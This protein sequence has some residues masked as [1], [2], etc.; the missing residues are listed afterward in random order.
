M[1]IP[2]T[3][4]AFALTSILNA[5]GMKPLPATIDMMDHSTAISILETI[6][7]EETR[8]ELVQLATQGSVK[9]L[10]DEEMERLRSL[11]DDSTNRILDDRQQS[12]P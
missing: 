9:T 8:V 1:T 5:S 10:D 2:G 11:I 6:T 4:L 12:F 7:P 3:A